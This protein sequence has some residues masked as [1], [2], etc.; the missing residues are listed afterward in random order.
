MFLPYIK[1]IL[2]DFKPN[3]ERRNKEINARMIG[4]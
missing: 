4:M 3:S 2:S 1:G